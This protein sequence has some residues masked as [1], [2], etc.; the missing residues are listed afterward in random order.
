[1]QPI[2]IAR[3][4][5]KRYNEL[6]AVNGVTFAVNQGECFGLLGPNGAGKTT[7]IR[8][9][10]AISPPTSGELFVDGKDVVRSGRQVRAILGVVPQGD[11]LDPDVSVYTNLL[12]HARF[13]GLPEPEA[14]RRVEETLEKVRLADRRKSE[15]DALSG[16]MKRRLAIGRA[17]LTRPAL[18]AIDEPTLGLD[19]HNRHL[20]WDWFRE[21]KRQ[22]TTLL[23]TTNNMDEASAL[24]DRLII[25]DH[26]RILAE[27]TPQEL[28]GTHAGTQ[29]LEI[30][31]TADRREMYR[32]RFAQRGLESYEAGSALI[33][34]MTD[35]TALSQELEH[36]GVS[37]LRR[38]ATLEDVFLRLTGRDINEDMR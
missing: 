25:I 1:M 38:P 34:P 18:L 21:V 30:R 9:V 24:C 28:V 12:I 11:D 8:M 16:G 13:Y 27:G 31:V 36:D 15:V 5:V 33:V 7:T 2:V 26:G 19:P 32:A 29:V 20:I 6:T 17:L 10:C 37:A 14:R 22:G 35:G 23:L 3:N 4:V